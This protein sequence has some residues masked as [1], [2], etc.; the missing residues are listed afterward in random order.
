MQI[1]RIHIPAIAVIYMILVVISIG[2]AFAVQANTAYG[3]VPAVLITLPWSLLLAP[4]FIDAA[5]VLFTHL[6]AGSAVLLA[7]HARAFSLLNRKERKCVSLV[8]SGALVHRTLVIPRQEFRNLR[9]GTMPSHS[10]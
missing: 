4:L 3:A 5:P 8:E 7:W 10:L 6:W 9:S 1:H 2:Y